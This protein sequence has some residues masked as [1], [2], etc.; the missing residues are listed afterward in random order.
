[1]LADEITPKSCAHWTMK[2]QAKYFCKNITNP[3]FDEKSEKY[4]TGRRVSEKHPKLIVIKT[5]KDFKPSPR[6]DQLRFKD[7]VTKLRLIF[8]E[9]DKK[10]I[11][12]ASNT[13]KLPLENTREIATDIGCSKSNNSFFS[14]VIRKQAH[15]KTV[16]HCDFHGWPIQLNNDEAADSFSPILDQG[17]FTIANLIDLAISNRGFNGIRAVP[18]NDFQKVFAMLVEPSKKMCLQWSTSSQVSHKSDLNEYNFTYDPLCNMAMDDD[19]V[20]KQL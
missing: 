18:T 1:M 3:F 13:P 16:F 9:T 10:A 17:F 11:E 4:A 14:L 12:S 7:E 8:K 15:L 20:D 6:S 2:D 19:M 5:S